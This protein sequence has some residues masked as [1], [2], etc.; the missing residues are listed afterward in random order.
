M[1]C[2]KFECCG[3][4]VHKIVTK[5]VAYPCMESETTEKRAALSR[6]FN[7]WVI[8]IT[9]ES[10][11]RLIRSKKHTSIAF[12]VSRVKELECEPQLQ[13]NCQG[14]KATAQQRGLGQ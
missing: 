10:E 7:V 12:G 8:L 14:G 9:H 4:L 3:V 1:K 6:N 11:L 2:V 5:Y 13:G